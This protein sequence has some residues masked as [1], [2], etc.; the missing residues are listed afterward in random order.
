[1]DR[2]SELQPE[3]DQLV[4]H[5]SDVGT[6]DSGPTRIP[7]QGVM[8]GIPR[9]CRRAMLLI[10]LVAASLGITVPSISHAAGKQQK[11]C[12]TT[13]AGKFCKVPS[14]TCKPCKTKAPANGNGGKTAPGPKQPTGGDAPKRSMTFGQVTVEAGQVPLP[15]GDENLTLEELA[16]VPRPRPEEPR[17]AAAANPSKFSFSAGARYVLNPPDSE[18][19]GINVFYRQG[20]LYGPRFRLAFGYQKKGPVWRPEMV[21]MLEGGKVEQTVTGN[22][23]FELIEPGVTTKGKMGS[24]LVGVRDGVRIAGGETVG[25]DLRLGVYVGGGLVS[26]DGVKDVAV[27]KEGE[28]ADLPALTTPFATFQG[29]VGLEGHAGPVTAGVD[30]CGQGAGNFQVQAG[31][32]RRGS[33]ADLSVGGE[34]GFDF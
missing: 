10:P 26:I 31:A 34:V 16:G 28:L 21:V 20:D 5:E 3:P 14:A 33:V 27:N 29:C 7:S 32:D 6:E 30:V 13:K 24:L 19:G 12:S 25:L 15:A 8:G 22:D 2:Y 4:E 1:M 18:L 9:L 17:K 23:E 11:L